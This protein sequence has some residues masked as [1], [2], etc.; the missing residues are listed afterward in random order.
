MRPKIYI[1]GVT[2]TSEKDGKRILKHAK[3][4]RP[5]AIFIES[6]ERL[7][8]VGNGKLASVF[9]RNPAFLLSYSVYSLIFRIWTKGRSPDL[10]YT[11]RASEKLGIPRHQIDDNVYQMTVSRHVGWTPISWAVL[12]LFLALTVSNIRFILLSSLILF[13][14]FFLLFVIFGVAT[15]NQHMMGRMENL[16]KSGV[17]EKAFLVTGKRHVPDFKKRL[18]KKYDIEDLTGR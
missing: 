5:N 11:K 8:K 10:V 7:F 12:A 6:A 3:E 4:L 1:I 2:H 16:I 15:R 9:L 18:S 17:Y 13:V 14:F